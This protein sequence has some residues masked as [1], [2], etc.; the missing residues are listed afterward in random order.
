M[1]NNNLDACVFTSYQN[2]LYYSGHLYYYFGRDYGCVVTHDNVCL[3]S[4]LVDGGNPWRR[5]YGDNLVYTDWHKGNYFHAV[6]QLLAD[7][8][9]NRIGLEFDHV[10]LDNHRKFAEVLPGSEFVDIGEMVM[11][12]RVVKSSAE[13]EVTRQGARIADIG[14]AAVVEALYEGTL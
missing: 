1:V 2:I 14:G 6:Q 9:A 12:T 5:C 4:A 8:S 10:S 3:I 11:R 13:Q 7:K